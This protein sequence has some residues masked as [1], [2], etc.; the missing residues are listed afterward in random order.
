M[1][2]LEQ[3]GRDFENNP[4]KATRKIIW[5][6]IGTV[7]LFSVVIGGINL[8]M[9]PVKTAKDIVEKT[10]DADHVLAEYQFFKQQYSDWKAINVK[11]ARADTSAAR[12]KRDAGPRSEWGFEDK[13][14]MSRLNSIADGLR[15]QREDIESK[16]NAK[17]QMLNKNLFKTN[18]LPAKLENGEEDRTYDNY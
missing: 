2:N 9:T 8:I 5:W 14:E 1:S 12:F 3:M 16:Y 18:D 17:S 6:I 7:L 11:V 4:K 13:N 15:Y 10:L